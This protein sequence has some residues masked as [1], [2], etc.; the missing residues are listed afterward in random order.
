MAL[1]DNEAME[2]LEAM[3]EDFKQNEASLEEKALLS[4]KYDNNSCILDS[5]FCHNWRHRAAAHFP[6]T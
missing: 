1:I 2:F 6:W 5:C 4:G 3:I